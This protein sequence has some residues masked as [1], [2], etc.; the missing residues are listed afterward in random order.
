MPQNSSHI[1]TVAAA[2]FLGLFLFIYA[3]KLWHGHQAAAHINKQQAHVASPGSC[4]LC[5]LQPGKD[6]EIMEPL[7]KLPVSV[8]ILVQTVRTISILHDLFCTARGDRG[9]PSIA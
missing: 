9:P 8:P 1:R 7:T 2:W 3:E 6:A 4:A 5:D